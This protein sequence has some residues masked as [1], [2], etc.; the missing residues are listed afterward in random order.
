MEKIQSKL[1]ECIEKQSTSMEGL[2]RLSKQLGNSE[3]PE[4]QSFDDVNKSNQET[5]VVENNGEDDNENKNETL[6]VADALETTT[7]RV[8]AEE[9]ELKGENKAPFRK[10]RRGR[11]YSYMLKAKGGRKKKTKERPKP[12]FFCQF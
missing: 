12:K 9:G 8:V 1:K 11:K 5:M 2:E 6:G 3:L 10:T 4:P 7:A